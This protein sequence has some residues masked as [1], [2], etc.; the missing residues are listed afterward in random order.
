MCYLLHQLYMTVNNI[1]KY[2]DVLDILL[3]MIHVLHAILDMYLVNQESAMLRL[4]AAGCRVEINV[5]MS[6]PN[7][8]YLI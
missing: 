4:T 6:N 2:I 3:M 7:E 5:S 1:H 8:Q